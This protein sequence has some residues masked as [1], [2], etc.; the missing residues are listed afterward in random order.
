[1]KIDNLQ[2]QRNI[3]STNPAQAISESTPTIS[4]AKMTYM[5]IDHYNGIILERGSR[6]KVLAYLNDNVG[7]SGLAVFRCAEIRF[8]HAVEL[9]E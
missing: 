3:N 7:K 9:E 5:V 2:R 6:A 8:R 1:M 4:S